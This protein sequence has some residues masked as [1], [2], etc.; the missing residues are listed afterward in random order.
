MS[1]LLSR[2]AGNELSAFILVLA[3]VTPLFIVAPL[4]SSALIPPR[5]RG[6][7][8]VGIAIGLT[9]VALH[10]QHV[11]SDALSLAGLV[12]EGLLVGF[13]FAL[14]LA[15]LVAA[16][17]SAGSI[18]DVVSGFSYGALINP[19]NNEQSAVMAR[20]YSL[21]GTLIFLVIGGDAWT[22]RGLG[23]TFELVPLTSGPKLG[24]LRRRPRA[25]IQHD[26]H[27]RA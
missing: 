3:R 19:L 23:R 25:G 2:L 12:L 9:P 26:L 16:I 15:V 21:V 27:L 10:G 5:V 8:A 20:F 7:I 22:L 18:I 14:S 11:P 24:S 17:E 4:F 1:Q 6:L 13:G